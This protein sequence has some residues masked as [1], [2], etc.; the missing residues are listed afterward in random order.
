MAN[1]VMLT[2]IAAPPFME[3]RRAAKFAELLREAGADSV[4]IDAE[5]NVI[6]LRRGQLG[7]RTVAVDA[8]L[9]TVFPEGTDVSVRRRGDTLLAPGI[10]DDTRGLAVVLT[11]LQAMNAA[12]LHTEADLLFIGTVGE[13][14]LGDLRGMKYLFRDGGPRIDVWISI[15]GV[16]PKRIVHGGLGSHRYRVTVRGPGGHSWG[17]FGLANPHHAL[18]MAVQKFVAAADPFT[19]S[20]PRTSYNVGRIGGG[21]SVNSIPFESWMEVDMRSVSPERLNGVDAL[22]QR[23]MREALEEANILRR[24]GDSLTMEIE[25]IGNRPSGVVSVD[26]SLVQAAMAATT[27]FDLE[28]VLT[29]SSTNSNIPISLGVPAIT[30]GSG[31]AGGDAH[32]LS[33]WWVNDN[34]ALGIKRALLIVLA[35]AGLSELVN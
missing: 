16:D 21:T 3:E 29:I 14:G 18:G 17:A 25:S 5:G 12:E 35:E 13:E 27:Y 32:A 20:G 4:W 1:H 10:G 2:E 33:E 7:Q 22:F 19:S 26:A 15:D 24:R 11:L 6:A 28:P 30:I 34:Q 9:D 8:H 31:G 23:A